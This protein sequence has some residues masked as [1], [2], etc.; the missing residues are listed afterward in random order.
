MHYYAHFI[1]RKLRLDEVKY[2]AQGQR[3]REVEELAWLCPRY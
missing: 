2:L 1:I 3:T